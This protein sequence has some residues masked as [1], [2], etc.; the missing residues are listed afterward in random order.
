MV[1]VQRPH[2]IVLQLLITAIAF[3]LTKTICLADTYVRDT[4]KKKAIYDMYAKYKK[5]SFSKIPDI[6]VQEAM[7][8]AKT[9]N[10]VLVDVRKPPEIK[11]SKLPGAIGQLEYLSDP[12]RY[13]GKTIVGYCTISFRSGQL[14]K[15]LLRKGVTMINLRG[16]ILAWLHEGG[17]VVD[18]E[19]KET[20][21]LHVYGKR[22]DLA[23]EGY[24]TITFRWRDNLF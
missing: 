4:D 21:R 10:I 19:E 15:K 3:C 23:P 13:E 22:W 24:K 9:S 18:K 14:A 20:H 8:L 11:V 1:N 2:Q 16:G 6:S 17:K 5:K 7:A 12:S